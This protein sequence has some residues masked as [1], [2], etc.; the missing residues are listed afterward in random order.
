[1][2]TMRPDPGG[3]SRTVLLL[4]LATASALGACSMSQTA[5]V[6]SARP[7]ILLILLD[8][9]G[10]DD[11]GVNGNQIV[12]TP[13]IDRLAAESVQFESF[14]VTPVCAPTRAALLTGRHHLRTG[15]SHVHGGKDFVDLGE[16]MLPE[17][18][19]GAG[20]AT[21]M[22]GKWHSGTTD[23]YLPWQRG[24]NEAFMAQLYVYFDNE[25]V[26][27]GVSDPQ[28]GWTPA[29]LTDKAIE[30]ISRHRDEPFF[31]YLPYLTVHAPLDAP[32]PLVA[33]Y[34]AKGLDGSLAVLYGM[35]DGV[36]SQVKRLLDV[37]AALGIEERTVVIFLSDNGPWVGTHTLTEE[38][39]RIR[40]VSGMRGH[41]GD[42]W[43][44]GV[45]S[46]LFVRWP[47][48]L[49]PR[50]VRRPAD[51]T[52]LFPTILA[53][54]G[55]EA[56]T[57]R[58]LDGRSLVPALEGDEEAGEPRRIYRYAHPGWI[59]GERPWTPEGL[60]GEYAPVDK[61]SLVFERQA[62][63]LRA[64]RDKLLLNPLATDH[65]GEP[66]EP[67]VVLVD[68]EEDPREQMNRASAEP[69]RAAALLAELRRWWNEILTEESSFEAPEF[70]VG[71]EGGDTALIKAAGPRAIEGEITNSFN[72]LTGW[73]GGGRAE[74]R[75]DVRT[76]GE[77]EVTAEFL[78]REPRSALFLMTVPGGGGRLEIGPDGRQTPARVVLPSGPVVLSMT[79]ERAGDADALAQ[80]RVSALVLRRP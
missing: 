57:S 76:P 26:T 69:Q 66:G 9:L 70:V 79:L 48:H 20:Y 52:D 72:A 47:G 78:G 24:F 2:T 54:A 31:A 29:R 64:G 4:V 55:V 34:R 21:G 62:L 50:L 36:D 8:D 5:K 27:N 45:R 25:G 1:M 42:V 37:L 18:L 60:P 74:F 41:K 28:K 61:S 19:K 56:K 49:E 33:K 32:E 23:G 63:A 12:E 17:L 6:P 71:W 11:L 73:G 38:E 39:H 15:V 43:E 65:E 46:P 59:S 53:L 77:Y 44:N 40:Y 67:H 13:H 10:Y 35:V 30:F 80:A 68:L 14:Y 22:W 3:A 7:N 75:L 51:V 58:P 16:M